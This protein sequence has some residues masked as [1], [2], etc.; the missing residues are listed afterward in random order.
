M[1]PR[2]ERVG[3]LFIDLKIERRSSSAIEYNRLQVTPRDDDIDDD[4]L[5]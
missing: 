5:W 2:H 3:K 1:T 4:D